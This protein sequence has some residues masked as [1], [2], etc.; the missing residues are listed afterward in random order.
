MRKEDTEVQGTE[1][2]REFQR[3]TVDGRKDC[4]LRC[5]LQ[6]G[7]TSVSLRKDCF[8]RTEARVCSARAG[9]LECN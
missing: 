2:G 3:A 8:A 6:R 4:N 9:M 7:I 1:L 5:V